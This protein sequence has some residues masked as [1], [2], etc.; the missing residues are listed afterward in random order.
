MP[1]PSGP[2]RSPRP[3]HRI[4]R[5]IRPHR[6]SRPPP[7]ATSAFTVTGALTIGCYRTFPLGAVNPAITRAVVVVHGSNRNNDHYFKAAADSA[8][9]AGVASEV[10]VV[11]PGFR[12]QED[13][14]QPNELYWDQEDWWK[15]GGPSTTALSPQV[16]SYEVMDRIV[17]ALADR[18]RF[19]NLRTIVVTGHSAGGQYVQ[20]YA[21]GTQA[22][23]ALAGVQLKF[24]VANPS[25][26]VYLNDQRPRPF[27]NEFWV[28]P[29]QPEPCAGYDTYKYGLAGRSGYMARLGAPALAAQY[30]ARDVTYLLG[31]SDADA[32]DDG[33]DKRCGGMLQGRFRLERGINYKAHM[34][35]FFAPHNHRV[36]LVPLIGHEGDRMYK[37]VE[38]QLVLFK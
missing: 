16:S 23:R 12:M 27:A 33:L 26:Y 1:S 32:N 21:V 4:P 35:R 38:G 19:P 11:A 9:A 37:S 36:V 28:P 13:K 8:V 34:D 29:Q 24:V 31:A 5:S 3:S 20:R 22:D 25:S 7:T 14:P 30:R 18:A 17:A 6:A 10:L 15:S 2:P